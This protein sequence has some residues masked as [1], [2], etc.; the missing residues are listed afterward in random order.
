MTGR[1]CKRYNLKCTF[2]RIACTSSRCV[3]RSP[4][5]CAKRTCCAP[6]LHVVLYMSTEAFLGA[7]SANTICAFLWRYNAVVVVRRR[8]ERCVFEM[9]CFP[10][11]NP[12]PPYPALHHCTNP[13]RAMTCV[14]WLEWTA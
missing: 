5:G 4:C 9:G 11:C 12:S 3:W 1:C 14:G 7:W 8:H 6:S 2:T 10:S 13:P